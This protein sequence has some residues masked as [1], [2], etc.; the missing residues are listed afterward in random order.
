MAYVD[1]EKIINTLINDWF[2]DNRII[3]GDN[4]TGDSCEFH[5]MTHEETEILGAFCDVTAIHGD[6]LKE[7]LVRGYIARMMKPKENN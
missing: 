5:A 1:S 3:L 4:E 2:T 6:D 7:V